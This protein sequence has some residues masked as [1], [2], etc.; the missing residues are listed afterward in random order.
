MLGKLAFR[1]VKRSAKDYLVYLLTMTFVTALMFSFNTVLF[2]E[3]IKTSPDSEGIMEILIGL[4]TFFVVLIVAWL[5][6]YMV[7]FMLDKRSREFGIYLLIG[8]ERKEITRLYI[9]E[10]LLLGFLAFGSG[11]V[12]GG[13]LQQVLFSILAHI[14]QLE[15]QIHLEYHK[16]CVLMTA[17]CYGGCYLLALL[18]CRKKFRKMSIHSLMNAEKQN[19]KIQESHESWKRILFPVSLLF[20]GVFGWWLLR[21]VIR[22]TGEIVGFLV[23]LVLVIYLF[24]MGLSSWIVCYIRKRG[25]KIY[26]GANLFLLRQF[27]S[28]IRS[29]QFTMGTLTSLFT[30]ALLGSTVALMLGDFQNQMLKGK[31]PFDVQIYSPDTEDDF[32][33]ELDILKKETNIKEIYR[34]SIYENADAQVNAWLYTHLKT[35]GT[36]Y[37]NPDGTPDEKAL[38]EEV[39]EHTNGTYFSYDT[40]MKVS[41]YNHLRSLLGYKEITLGKQ[42]YALH[43]KERIYK[44]TGDFSSHLKIKADETELLCSGIYTEPF[45]QDGHNG[46]DYII[47]VPDQTVEGMSP[48]YAELVVQIQGKA[49]ENL[50]QTLDRRQEEKEETA[51]H[52]LP[53]GNSGY[54][55]DS[56]VSYYSKNMVRDNL[57]P[58][59]KYMLSSITF[60]CFYIGLVFLCAAFTVLA[61]QQLSDSAKYKF[62]YGVLEQLGLNRREKEQVIWKQLAAYYLCPALFAGVISGMISVFISYK[63][64]FYTGVEASVIRYFT[65]SC[66]LFFGIY[67][68]Y[69][70]ATYVGFKRNVNIK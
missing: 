17:G 15:Y 37:Q 59:I 39:E 7:R 46:A 45:S 48:Y 69:F 30:L 21:G 27:S 4:A 5:I 14:M 68:L 12:L 26:H 8:M 22:D 36:M 52:N 53:N 55:S 31:F 38:L 56:I 19:E 51:G 66:G 2:S 44:E 67:A 47:I 42:Q 20:M 6:H 28:K 43:M 57:I 25:R 64:I 29:M 1:N 35:F 24:Y 65:A 34:Y 23:G 10:N 62:R 70:V 50:Q 33:Q 3:Q 58:E 61:V 11:L 49:P 32:A 54:G 9:R 60:P 13:L 41:D 16:S 18:R 40:Y 63:F